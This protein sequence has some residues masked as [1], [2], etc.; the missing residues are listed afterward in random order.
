MRTWIVTYRIIATGAIAHSSE[1]DSPT[2]E[3]AFAWALHNCPGTR[4]I[5]SVTEADTQHALEKLVQLVAPWL[6]IW[7]LG[8]HD[9]KKRMDI[10]W[11]YNNLSDATA[12]VR[13]LEGEG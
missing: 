8:G 6:K 4:Q 13:K 11:Q 7:N 5:V 9:Y 10:Y 2:A 1:I 12:A 3:G